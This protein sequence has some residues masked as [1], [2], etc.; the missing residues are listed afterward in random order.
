V[1]LIIM[2]LARDWGAKPAA[3]GHEPA[4]NTNTNPGSTANPAAT[5]DRLAEPPP[6]VQANLTG[7]WTDDFGDIIHI[8]QTGDS[9]EFVAENNSTHVAGRGRG[10]V[11]GQSF[12]NSYQT[13]RPSTG[14]G[15]GMISVDGMQTTGTY[16][17]SMVGR[18]TLVLYRQQ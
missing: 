16:F 1:G 13:N 3:G 15:S 14:S 2:G 10:T 11:H 4:A 9:F 8:T 7:V 12:T 17:D 6:P 18:Y 5:R